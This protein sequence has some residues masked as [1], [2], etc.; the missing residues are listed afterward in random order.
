MSALKQRAQRAEQDASHARNELH[1]MKMQMIRRSQ[2]FPESIGAIMADYEPRSGGGR[3]AKY[4]P[5]SP[6]AVDIDLPPPAAA[7]RQ[8]A[9]PRPS[10]SRNALVE[11]S[12]VADSTFIFPKGQKP[13]VANRPAPR[14]EEARRHEAATPPPG[15]RPMSSVMAS[16]AAAMRPPTDDIS[17]HMH[18]SDQSRRLGSAANR[19]PDSGKALYGNHRG[20]GDGSAMDGARWPRSSNDAYGGAGGS[21]PVSGRVANRPLSGML[22]PRPAISVLTD[23]GIPEGV[24][25]TPV[26]VDHIL[27]RNDERLRA[28]QQ[29]SE[30]QD[31]EALEDF[32]LKYAHSGPSTGVHPRKPVSPLRL[33]T[34]RGDTLQASALKLRSVE[35]MLDDL[36][37]DLHGSLAAADAS[38]SYLNGPA[39]TSLGQVDRPLHRYSA[40][41]MMR[42]PPPVDYHHQDE[43][44][45]EM[46]SLG[47]RGETPRAAEDPLMMAVAAKR[48]AI[49]GASY[50][51]GA[52]AG[53]YHRDSYSGVEHS[54]Q[55]LIGVSKFLPT[56]SG[57]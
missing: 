32:L 51:S 19:R 44:D 21:R 16:H 55:S 24:P 9:S 34:P 36:A 28:L 3:R 31:P 4:S 1:H 5:Q 46:R 37:S 14:H 48:P 53:G 45:L 18:F 47:L 35:S 52:M 38:S 30:P 54:Q 2:E 23:A 50:A 6:V 57:Y 17:G 25:Q 56:S 42:I 11:T 27:S 43:L 26:D 41:D 10:S 33:S 22:Q 20:G 15:H 49:G 8:P 12:L 39:N 13:M 7:M 29:M 40:N